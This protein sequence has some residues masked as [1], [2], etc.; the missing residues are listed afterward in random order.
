ML[1]IRPVALLAHDLAGRFQGLGQHIE[2]GAD[3]LGSKNQPAGV[4]VGF[5]AVID[6]GG[7]Q[8]GFEAQG[9][10]EALGDVHQFGA[11]FFEKRCIPFHLE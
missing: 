6:A 8:D 11:A 9:V 4:T 10:L 2:E 7:G 5:D 1:F 3:A